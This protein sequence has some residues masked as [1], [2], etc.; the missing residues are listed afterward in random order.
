[1]VR[2]LFAFFAI[3]MGAMA[4]FA[5]TTPAEQFVPA[6]PN[7]PIL[8]VEPERLFSSSLFGRRIA[9]ELAD[10][11][12]ALVADKEVIEQQ[13]EQEERELTE[14]RNTVDA[15]EFAR[16]ADIFDAKVQQL[17]RDQLERSREF[18]AR[19]ERAQQE[20]FSFALPVLADLVRISGAVAILERRTVFLAA[21]SIDITD[22][23]IARINN[24]LGDGS[25]PSPEE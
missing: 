20:F 22:I 17:R 24:E 25:N 1:M 2:I 14:L 15:A 5:Q 21:D 19:S 9:A 18:T 10:E 3:W 8:T 7:S 23:A 12:E 6:L 16:L 11:R 13:L 4:A